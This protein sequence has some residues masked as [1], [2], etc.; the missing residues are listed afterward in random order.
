M[1]TVNLS[2]IDFV[3]F[4]FTYTEAALIFSMTVQF[5]ITLSFANAHVFAIIIMKYNHAE[6]FTLR[7]V[8][9]TFLLQSAWNILF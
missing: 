7:E 2:L 9:S 1:Q 8:F 4:A 5:R 6:V 3:P